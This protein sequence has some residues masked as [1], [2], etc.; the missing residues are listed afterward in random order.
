MTKNDEYV[1]TSEK[2]LKISKDA[3]SAAVVEWFFH[4]L[5]QKQNQ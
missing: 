3:N 2:L 4:Q 5:Q 1:E